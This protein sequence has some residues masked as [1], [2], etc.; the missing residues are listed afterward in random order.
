MNMSFKAVGAQGEVNVGRIDALPDGLIAVQPENGFLIVGHSEKGHHHGFRDDGSVMVMERVRDVP[1]G[2][3]ILYAIV[4]NPTALVQDSPSPHE[5][6][7]LDPGIYEIRISRE[8]NPFLDE[9]R[10]VKD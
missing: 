1:S 3:T 5:R 6:L 7:L 2:M 9:A 10:R 8:Y 4:E